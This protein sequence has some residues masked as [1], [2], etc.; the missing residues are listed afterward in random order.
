M[1][2]PEQ[3][4]PRTLEDLQAEH[5][6]HVGSRHGLPK[7]ELAEQAPFRNYVRDLVL[8][9]NDGL[10]SVYAVTAGVVGASFGTGAIAIAGIAAA[11]AGALSM[12]AGEYISTKSQAQYYHSE[13]LREEE[14]LDR[15]PELE[16]QELRDD[17]AAMGLEPPMLD[18]VVDTLA[19]DRDRFLDYMMRSEF[20]VGDESNRSP[21]AAALLV[22]GAFI[23]GSIAPVAPYTLIDDAWLALQTSSVLSVLGLFFAGFYRARISR[24]PAAPAGLEM[25]AVG[26][27]AAAITFGVGRLIGYAL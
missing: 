18:A 12:G 13:R 20:G 1:D 7:G 15:W 6:H 16:K 2:G 21:L 11:V 19:K 26:A 14:H 22:M 4:P 10:V 9:F 8:G 23:V 24:L 17:F 25:V 27:A 3:Q 5:G